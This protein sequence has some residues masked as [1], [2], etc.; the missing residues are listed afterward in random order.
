MIPLPST[1]TSINHTKIIPFSRVAIP[2]RCHPLFSLPPSSAPLGAD[3]RACN[4]SARA[5]TR[6]R[7]SASPRRR[8]TPKDIFFR[9]RNFELRVDSAKRI[10]VFLLA[11]SPRKTGRVSQ[12]GWQYYTYMYEWVSCSSISSLP[13]VGLLGQFRLSG[14]HFYRIFYVVL[15][16]RRKFAGRPEVPRYPPHPKIFTRGT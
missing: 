4:A 8:N 5:R 14:E 10:D 13:P 3:Y 16:T 12:W 15:G 1:S 7:R 9:E 6:R 11:C 2:T